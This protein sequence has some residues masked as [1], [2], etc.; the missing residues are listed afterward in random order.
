MLLRN[1]RNCDKEMSFDIKHYNGLLIYILL[2]FTIYTI[3]VYYI[4]Y[5]GLNQNYFVC[6]TQ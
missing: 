2:W 4:H 6:K 5:Y 1:H 3:M